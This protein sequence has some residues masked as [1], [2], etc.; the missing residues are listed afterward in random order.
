LHYVDANGPHKE[1]HR[2]KRKYWGL[3]A[4]NGI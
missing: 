3:G 1:W 4:V 2:D